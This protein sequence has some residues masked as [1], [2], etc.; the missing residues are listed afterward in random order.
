MAKQKV[1]KCG[2]LKEKGWLYYLDK[3]GNVSRAK[4]VRRGSKKKK[5]APE[6]LVKCNVK[7]ED[8]FLYF[9]DKNGDVARTKMARR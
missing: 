2:V 4:M 8:G 9:I 7:R 6:V 3:R 5:A 1:Y